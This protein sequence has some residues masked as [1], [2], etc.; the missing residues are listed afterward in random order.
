MNELSN[1]WTVEKG[2]KIAK[3]FN[4]LYRRLFFNHI[5]TKY[6]LWPIKN[7]SLNFRGYMIIELIALHLN[8]TVASGI[9][10]A[11]QLSGIN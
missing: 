8:T 11:T 7:S 5:L 2:G 4:M 10:K 3:I 6:Y 1:R 9:F